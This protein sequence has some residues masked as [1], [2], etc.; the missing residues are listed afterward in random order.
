MGVVIGVL[1]LL[2]M[3]FDTPP[4]VREQGV[5]ELVVR[6]SGQLLAQAGTDIIDTWSFPDYLDVR[7]AAS[8]MAVTG[9]SRGE[10]LLQLAGEDTAVSL[11]AMYVSSNYFSTVGLSLPLGRGFTA[12][13][14]ASPAE[15]EAVVS[16]RLW[17]QRFGGDPNIIGRAV[18]INHARYVVVGVA[19]P[20]F[21]GH[22]SGLNEAQHQIWL[23]LSRHPRL[24]PGTNGSDSSRLARDAAWVHVFARLA[25]DTTVVQAN[26]MVQS[27]MAALAQRYASTNREKA[28][29]AEPY[30]APGV[31]VKSKFSLIRMMMFGLSGMVLLVV[32][33]NISG[34]ILVRSAMREREL[35]VRLAMGASRWRL[36]RHHLSEALVMALLGGSLA[37]AL[38][39]GVPVLIAWWVDGWGPVVDI[40]APDP[41]LALECV[42]LCFVTTLVLGSCRRFGSAARRSSPR[43][44]A[45]P[46]PRAGGSGACSASPPR[47]R[48]ASP[49]RFS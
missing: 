30:F 3:V 8:G 36:M 41:W 42:A 22:V 9:W 7:G 28:G 2:R 11:P 1:L 49:S 27:A 34:M 21:R 4:G 37:S 43:S 10:A 16:R 39:F 18:T 35:A 38:L 26:A 17:Q 47:P 40:F 13:D 6:P 25:G 46:L 20:G 32:G 45:I 48:R 31:R 33:L 29:G 15:P 44:R 5:V 14:D 19:P 23:P 24:Q 12:A